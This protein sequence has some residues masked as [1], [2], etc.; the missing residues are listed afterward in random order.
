MAAAS[1]SM[2]QTRQGEPTFRR[3]QMIALVVG[4]IGLV[5]SAAGW[6]LNPNSFFP[7]YLIAV[8]FWLGV[9]WGAM[10]VA[11]VYY[12]A[13]GPWGAVIRTFL[14]ASMRT[15]PLMAVLFLPLLL[16]IPT[17]YIWARPDIV[18]QSDIMQYKVYQIGW[19]TVPFFIGRTILYFAIWLILVFVLNRLSARQNQTGDP[20]IRQ[21]MGRWSAAGMI[22]LMLT[23][24]FAAFDWIMSINPTF[25]ST[26]FGAV[27]GTSALIAGFAVIITVAALLAYREP[28]RHVWSFK[29]WM[30]LGGWLFAFTMLWAYL[31]YSQF[32]LIWYGN[33]PEETL[34]YI[35]R[36][37]GVWAWIIG[38][39]FLVSFVA[40][41]ILLLMPQIKLNMRVMAVVGII[42]AFMRLV[43]VYWWVAPA[44]SYDPATSWLYLTAPIGVG[45]LWVWFF[46]WQLKRR[47]YLPLHDPKLPTL[48]EVEHDD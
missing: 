7:A 43:D 3:P 25:V 30:N 8:F 36:F 6:L 19:L 2:T 48:P 34:P 29:I 39:I 24:T 9:V 27:E 32:M 41:F 38:A 17:L 12:L 22:L 44:Y 18:A 47:P 45:G 46:L 20:K 5:A 4:I 11:M 35:R 10:A 40:P 42:L 14:E 37:E 16:G 23:T 33:L 13:G 26:A 15:M 1:P 31:A 21:S 28:W